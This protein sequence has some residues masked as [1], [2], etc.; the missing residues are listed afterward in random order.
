MWEGKWVAAGVCL[1]VA[2]TAIQ[3]L[4]SSYMGE[5]TQLKPMEL[6]DQV[7]VIIFFGSLVAFLLL[8][9]V[10]RNKRKDAR[11]LVEEIRQRTRRDVRDGARQ[12]SEP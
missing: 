6:G 10:L 5:N 3:S 2:P 12:V 8:W 11:E 4:A 7:Q 1:G 9:R